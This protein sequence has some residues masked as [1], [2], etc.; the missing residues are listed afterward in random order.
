MNGREK[1]KGTA[2]RKEM[3]HTRKL[4]KEGTQGRH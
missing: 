3:R 4:H 1:T 2:C